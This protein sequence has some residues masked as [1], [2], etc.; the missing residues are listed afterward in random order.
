MDLSYII[1]EIKRYIGRTSQFFYIPPAFDVR[2]TDD[3]LSLLQLTTPAVWRR[4]CS[5]NNSCGLAASRTRGRIKFWTFLFETRLFQRASGE[6]F[7][8]A[9]QSAVQ[10]SIY[11]SIVT[12]GL[13]RLVFE[14][15]V[16]P[17][18]GKRTGGRRRS[19]DIGKHLTLKT[20]SSKLKSKSVNT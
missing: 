6:D 14:I 4:S 18:E 15:H 13:S 19:S 8:A 20:A 12:I 10:T 11:C 2:Q 7:D 16:W 9:T 17:W 5:V 3:G 1:S